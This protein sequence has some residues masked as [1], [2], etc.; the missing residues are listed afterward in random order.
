MTYAQMFSY[1]MFPMYHIMN[2]TVF[3]DMRLFRRNVFIVSDSELNTFRQ[4]KLGKKCLG[5]PIGLSV[6]RKG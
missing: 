4:L 1:K 2:C 5:S 6:A 3:D